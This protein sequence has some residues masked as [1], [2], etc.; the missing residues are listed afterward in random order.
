MFGC[1]IGRER[2]TNIWRFNELTNTT[3]ITD[4]TFGCITGTD[5]LT[6]NGLISSLSLL[7]QMELHEH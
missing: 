1:I 4:I 5:L 6:F 2:F 3:A 7:A